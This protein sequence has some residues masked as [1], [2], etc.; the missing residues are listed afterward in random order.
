M[1]E[2]PQIC[3]RCVWVHRYAGGVHGATYMQEVCM[4]SQICRRCA[5]VHRYAGG[6]HGSTDMQEVCMGP[7]ICRRCV[8][9]HIYAGGV[10][11]A[12]DMQ[13]GPQICRR[14]VWVHIYA[15]GVHGSTDMQEVCMGPHNRCAAIPANLYLFRRSQCN[16]NLVNS[17]SNRWMIQ[18]MMVFPSIFYSRTKI[19]S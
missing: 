15:G 12:T 8:W 5:W 11:G 3:R 2:G 16:L 1:Q 14:C 7:H 4:G 18:E 17:S 19:R 10:H 13:E 6:L 9:V